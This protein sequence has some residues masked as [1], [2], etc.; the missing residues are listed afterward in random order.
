VISAFF[1]A[2]SLGT[3]AADGTLPYIKPSR[4]GRE[5]ADVLNYGKTAPSFPHQTTVDQWFDKTQFESQRSRG[6]NI[7]ASALREP[8]RTSEGNTPEP[9]RDDVVKL[10]TSIGKKW[11]TAPPASP[12]VEGN[13]ADSKR[14]GDATG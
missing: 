11:G 5:L 7:G 8:T 4:T 9:G 3:L 1:R 6:Y 12:T 2:V 14:G 10:C 13:R